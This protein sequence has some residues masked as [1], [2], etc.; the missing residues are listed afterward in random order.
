MAEKKV[1][2]LA[3]MQGLVNARGLVPMD[4]VVSFAPYFKGDTAGFIPKMAYQHYME[5]R[6]VPVGMSGAV[7]PDQK[8][9]KRGSIGVT[10]QKLRQQVGTQLTDKKGKEFKKDPDA[11]DIPAN[12]ETKEFG[13]LNRIRLAAKLTGKPMKDVGKE[14]GAIEIIK[15]ELEKRGK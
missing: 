6:A 13:A 12:W 11:I 10:T 8:A 3:D 2:T 7:V 1:L 14:P 9:P 5:G 15:A 4:I